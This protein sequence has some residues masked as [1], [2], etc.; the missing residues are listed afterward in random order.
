MQQ[1]LVVIGGGAA[2]IFCAVNAARLQPSLQIIVIEKSNKLLAKVKISGGGRCNVTHNHTSVTAM[3][4]CYPRGEKFVKKTMQH[5]FVADTLQWFADRAV[6]IVAEADGRMFPKSNNS[7]SIINCLMQEADKYKIKILMQTSVEHIG[8]GEIYNLQLNNNTTLS[9]NYLCIATGGGVKLE[10]F[11]WLHNLKHTIVA[12]VPSLFTFNVPNAPITKLMGV[13]A[14]SAC[15]KIKDFTTNYTGPVLITHWG[16]SGPAVLK[17]SAFAAQFLHSKHYQYDISINWCAEY[18]ESKILH[19][20]RLWRNS[21]ATQNVATKNPLQL[22]NRL[23]EFLLQESAIPPSLKWGELNAKQ[24]NNL[25]INLCSYALKANGK[26]TYKEE[27]VTAGGITLDEVDA[28][29][30]MSLK[31]N[32]LFFAGEVLNIDGITGGF[33]FQNAWTTGFVVANTISKSIK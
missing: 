17:L 32:N 28:N 13:V 29:T 31:H 25:A 11:A 23:W 22:V 15:I 26:T 4:K 24:Q 19:D 27:F 7:E 3:S 14:Q 16:L 9:C 21:M 2:G 33:N 6:P 8:I 5:F 12:P 20:I 30:C 10:Q 1:T 18:N